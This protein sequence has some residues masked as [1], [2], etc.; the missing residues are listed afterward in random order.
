MDDFMSIFKDVE[1]KKLFT[2]YKNVRFLTGVRKNKTQYANNLI[3]LTH[4]YNKLTKSNNKVHSV[5]TLNK[6]FTMKDYRELFGELRHTLAGG[7][8]KQSKITNLYKLGQKTSILHS[9]FDEFKKAPQAKDWVSAPERHVAPQQLQQLPPDLDNV[10][11][12][13]CEFEPYL[14]NY[15]DL[16]NMGF[17]FNL[18][19]N[20]KSNK[21]NN[22]NRNRKGKQKQRKKND[23]LNDD[24]NISS[25]TESVE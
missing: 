25:H 6:H 13:K 11:A 18:G 17:D 8:S 3:N 21:N 15:D 5:D 10:V 14:A 20:K 2:F 24:D 19:H 16:P 9:Y 22:V 23:N 1:K 7:R 12:L 4:L